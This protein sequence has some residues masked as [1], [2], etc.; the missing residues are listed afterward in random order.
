MTTI[1]SAAIYHLGVVRTGK[2]HGEC[3]RQLPRDRK[4]P[5]DVQGFLT[6][7]GDFVDRREAFGIAM[8][9]GQLSNGYSRWGKLFSEDLT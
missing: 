9:A 1:V 7:R 5:Y 3:M 4:K 6:S 2:N 8:A